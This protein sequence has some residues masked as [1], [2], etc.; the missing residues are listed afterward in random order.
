M[1]TPQFYE[2]RQSIVAVFKSKGYQESS[3]RRYANTWDNIV[4]YMKELDVETY[5]KDVG[6]SFFLK[7]LNKTK[8]QYNELT[9]RQKEVWRHILV[10][11]AMVDFG[12]VNHMDMYYRE[13]VFSGPQGTYFISFLEYQSKIKRPASLKRYKSDLKVL[14]QYLINNNIEVVKIDIPIIIKFIEFCSNAKK[15][16][17]MND[18]ITTT[19][20][21]IRYLCDNRLINDTRKEI[22]MTAIRSRTKHAAKI[23]S[24]Y[25]PNEIEQIIQAPD[26]SSPIG[27]RD[28]A[29]VLLAARYGLRVSDI[30][31]LQFKNVDW[32]NNSLNILQV[33]T[34]KFVSLP[35]SEEVGNAIIEYIKYGRPQ[36][37]LPYIFVTGIAPYKEISSNV[38]SL[39]ISKWIRM[40]GI[41]INRRKTGAHSLRHSLATNLLNINETLPVISEIL[42]HSTSQSTTT[43]LRVSYEQLRQCAL[44]VPLVPTNFYDNLYNTKIY[45]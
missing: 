10:L 45:E 23:P 2:L 15:S 25:T 38:L 22:W 6:N 26:R 29:M 33:K 17:C 32:E 28:Y 7:F 11:N 14:Y 36:V 1:E 9:H 44:S 31:N 41:D 37:D 13:N 40:A 5:T 8:Y 43:Y 4:V 18:I 42:G 35:L 27:K 21:F 39:N 20:L 16:C 19:R 3:I 24:V 12:D 34:H 30:I